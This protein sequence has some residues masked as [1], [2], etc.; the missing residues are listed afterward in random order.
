MIGMAENLPIHLGDV[1][2]EDEFKHTPFEDLG[3]LIRLQYQTCM[4]NVI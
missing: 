3:G 4:K 1:R 2:I